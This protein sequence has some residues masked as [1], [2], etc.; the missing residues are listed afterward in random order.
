MKINIE[1]LEAKQAE[2]NQKIEA[3]LN[4]NP[5]EKRKE[6]I[7]RGAINEFTKNGIPFMGYFVKEHYDSKGDKH[8]VQYNNFA[9]ITN[10]YNRNL[11]DGS[12]EEM[13]M[14]NSSYAMAFLNYIECWFR[15]QESGQDLTLKQKIVIYFRVHANRLAELEKKGRK[16]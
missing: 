15:M 5:E 10:Y 7:I 1:Q 3:F 6:D 12:G 11:E 13:G 2:I 4:E 16:L 8:F 9:D 14:L